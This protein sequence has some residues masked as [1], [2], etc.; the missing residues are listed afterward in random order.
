[1]VPTIT[2]PVKNEVKSEFK[3]ENEYRKIKKGISNKSWISEKTAIGITNK[4][5]NL[6]CLFFRLKNKYQ[7]W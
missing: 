5:R 2:I 3:I 1:M 7:C 6:L 4:V